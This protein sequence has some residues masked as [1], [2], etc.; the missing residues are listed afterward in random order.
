[1]NCSPW[2][3]KESDTTEQLNWTEL[4]P[5]RMVWTG[6]WSQGS[7]GKIGQPVGFPNEFPASRSTSVPL[8]FTLGCRLIFWPVM[9]DLGVNA[10]T[11]IYAL[12]PGTKLT[13]VGVG[14]VGWWAFLG[15]P[16]SKTPS[17]QCRGCSL[18]RELDPTNATTE[19]SHAISED[20]A[21]CDD[22]LKIHNWGLAWS[23]K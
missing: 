3:L 12:W 14:I 11:C 22:D 6:D 5:R 23:N 9:E 15:G 8:N 16:V 7:D 20:P 17:C 21:C 10:Q 19:S 4:T 13:A 18:V 1:M 2:G